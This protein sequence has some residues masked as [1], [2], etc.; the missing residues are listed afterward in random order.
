MCVVQQVGRH[1]IKPESVFWVTKEDENINL[2]VY[3]FGIRK[4]PRIK[5]TPA[6]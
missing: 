2:H 1:N 4:F 6:T 5:K 3:K